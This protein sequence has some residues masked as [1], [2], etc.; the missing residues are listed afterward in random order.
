MSVLP[1]LPRLITSAIGRMAWAWSRPMF[2][3]TALFEQ[4]ATTDELVLAWR[5]VLEMRDRHVKLTSVDHCIQ[6]AGATAWERA[7]IEVKRWPR[8]GTSTG[9]LAAG[10]SD[11]RIQQID[12]IEIAGAV[13][14]DVPAGGLGDKRQFLAPGGLAGPL[15][16]YQAQPQCSV[17]EVV[18]G[19][20][21]V[22][23]RR[24]LRMA[25]FLMVPGQF[26]GRPVGIDG[27]QLDAASGPGQIAAPP[28]LS[29]QL[30]QSLADRSLRH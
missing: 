15:I 5:A 23:A 18:G 4:A 14:L 1:R 9:N 2:W 25:C 20:E 17:T 27:V 26:I 28:A 6:A 12:S 19:G 30:R 21:P 8:P 11:H 29:F 16:E 10:A 22:P 24:R 3:V 7:F 13:G